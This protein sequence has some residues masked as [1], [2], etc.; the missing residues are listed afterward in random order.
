M[1]SRALNKP[2]K[3]LVDEAK[4]VLTYLVQT[5]HVGIRYCRGVPIRLYGMSDSDWTT[6]RS[7]SGF[8]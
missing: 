4:R 7:T 5:K 6:R 1:L 2:T 8:A 3:R